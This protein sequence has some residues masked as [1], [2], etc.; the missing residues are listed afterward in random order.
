MGSATSEKI[1]ILHITEQDLSN[2]T[3]LQPM[4]E[5]NV[6]EIVDSCHRTIL[7]IPQLETIINQYSS[8]E[9][10]RQ[11]LTRHFIELFNGVID[12]EFVEKRLCV[13][14]I[15]YRIGLKPDWYMGVF[16]TLQE[17]V[18]QSVFELESQ[19]DRQVVL[20]QSSLKLLNLKQQIVVEKYEEG[21][22][23]QQ[24]QQYEQINLDLKGKFLT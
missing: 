4:I 12:D 16:Q 9:K 17:W 22:F 24:S 10:L 20:I 13:A 18:I 6:P 11:T 5:E 1:T 14:M 19:S 15:H 2:I 3:T 7:V 8:V 21:N 23:R